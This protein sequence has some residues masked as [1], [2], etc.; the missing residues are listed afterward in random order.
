VAGNRADDGLYVPVYQA[1]VKA[2]GLSSVLVV[3]DSKM[4]ALA[5]R[6]HMVAGQSAYLCA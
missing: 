4:G 5:T 1:A 6:G 2:L 3:G